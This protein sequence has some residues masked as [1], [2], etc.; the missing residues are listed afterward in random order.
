M[1]N[2]FLDDLRQADVLIHVIDASGSTNDKGEPVD[3]LSYDPANDI[4]F[5][6]EELDYWYLGILTKGWEKFARSVNVSGK[7]ITSSVAELKNPTHSL[8]AET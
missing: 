2:Q 5:L 1:G 6:E 3:A 4:R 8:R 7:K